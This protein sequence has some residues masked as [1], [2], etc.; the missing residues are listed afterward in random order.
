MTTAHAYIGDF[1][2]LPPTAG[3]R[4]HETAHFTVIYPD[5]L[6]GEAADTAYFLEQAYKKAGETF[7]YY[8]DHKVKVIVTD[9]HDN[10]NGLTSAVGHQGIV[11]Y[12]TAPEP[13][14]TLGDYGHW[15]WD[16]IIHEYAH[17]AT[18]E[19]RRGIYS[20]TH[21]LTGN[22]LFPNH[23]WPQWLAEGMAVY[24][25]T[26]LTSAGRGYGTYYETLTRDGIA[27]GTLGTDK[28][29]GYS[30]IVGPVPRYP[31]GESFY[32][33]GFAI[34]DEL[35]H[36]YGKDAPARYAAESSSRFPFF[37]DGALENITG[38]DS[39]SFRNLWHAWITR[40]RARL[41][42]EIE[43][44]A[45]NGTPE[46]KLLSPEGD[47][48]V[49]ARLSPDGSKL[50]FMRSSGHQV[51]GLDLLDT[52][53][54]RRDRIDDAVASGQLAWSEDG[55]TLYFSK[56]DYDG[57]YRYFSDVYAY[58]LARRSVTRVTRGLHAKDPSICG[59]KLYF[60]ADI[61]AIS[62][63]RS[64]DLKTQV[65]E[66]LYRAP[67]YFHVANPRCFNDDVIF[68]QHGTE[69]FDGL[70]VMRRS[71]SATGSGSGAGAA[72]RLIAGGPSARFSALFGDWISED[73][74]VLTKAQ[75]GYFELA[76]LGL[77]N[78]QI[79]TIA[80]STGGYWLPQ[81]VGD[82]AVVTYLSSAGVQA[83]LMPWP[84]KPL[85]APKEASKARESFGGET[86]VD[87][88][89]EQKGWIADKPYQTHSYNL[90]TSLLPRIWLPFIG[91]DNLQQQYG[92][93]VIGWDDVDQLEYLLL[94]WYDSIS[95]KPE[96]VVTTAHRLAT[97]RLDLTG[98]RKVSDYT[99]VNSIL[100]FHEEAKLTAALSRPFLSDFSNFTPALVA[101]VS[102]TK[103]DGD[104]GER[105]FS[106]AQDV[107][108]NL[109]YS[110]RQS[111][112]YAITPEQGNAWLLLG[113]RYFSAGDRA[114]KFF[115][116]Y[117]QL[118]PAGPE[119]GNFSLKLS[120]AL[121]PE[122]QAAIPSSI[123]KV[124]G[125]AAPGDLDLPLR[126]YPLGNFYVQRGGVLQAEYRLPIAQVF[127]GGGNWPLFTRNLGAYAFYDGAKLQRDGYGVTELLSGIGGGM[128]VNAAVAYAYPFQIRVEFAHGLQRDFNGQSV[129]SVLFSY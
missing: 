72:P 21:V 91:I 102:Q 53:T 36:E 57:P 10:A 106:P 89:G 67:R 90:L 48:A 55:N 19:Q 124:G 76:S 65:A 27:K 35:V 13:Y 125:R 50:A 128:I 6:E 94:G 45:R 71:G 9:N 111:A 51:P 68:S 23:L 98:Q 22:L 26:A 129:F 110:S 18:L 86:R 59:D 73:R 101:E 7:H 63:V 114:W 117:E 82:T 83:G 113:R 119:H 12:L 14:S 47:L 28:L 97:L 109:T 37:L 122:G 126:G 88:L 17:Y 41:A 105:N 85:A 79:Q 81:K 30:R 16:L 118:V 96:G 77:N 95:S 93:A 43:E 92:A 49:G 70:Y 112:P 46:P 25:E 3:Y 84:T 56:Y 11:L 120:A 75:N 100:I 123:V 32:F 2:N 38:T 74:I 40:N 24:A 39:R 34:I 115:G 61:G 5:T 42:P 1:T 44:L 29:L 69:P 54:N 121:T 104:A 127:H 107:G 33:S 99:S 8:P 66:T 58:D 78:N 31:F 103:R 60:T 15:L 80:R 108:F 116:S 87:P 62:E 52:K 20:V 64:F 4:Q